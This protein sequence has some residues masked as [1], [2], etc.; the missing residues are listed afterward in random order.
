MRNVSIFFVAILLSQQAAAVTF[1]IQSLCSD[2]FLLTSEINAAPDDSVGSITIRALDKSTLPYTGSS[3]GISS[4]D[5]SP[6]G[7]GALEVISSTQMR[8]Y[9]WCYSLNGVE[10]DAMPNQVL[11]SN[12]TD[13]IHWYFGYAE[14]KDG[15]W[16]TYCTPTHVA[17]PDFICKRE[18]TPGE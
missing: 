11:I 7:D 2:K 14:Y 12:N 3:E 10:P 6:T 15:Q 13:V 8:A 5:N 16:I 1:K 4:I 17:R 9:G 18:T